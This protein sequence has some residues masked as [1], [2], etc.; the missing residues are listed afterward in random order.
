[1][2]SV[3]AG[4]LSPSRKLEVYSTGS[5]SPTHPDGPD[6]FRLRDK[7]GIGPFD[8]DDPDSK[9]IWWTDPGVHQNLAFAARSSWCA[10]SS[11]AAGRSG[12]A[13]QATERQGCDS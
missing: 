1:M 11:R 7:G 8:S 3:T 10:R 12:W 13:S 4:W 5:T 6:S 9:R 2:G